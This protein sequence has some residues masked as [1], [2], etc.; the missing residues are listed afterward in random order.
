M[1]T[2][3]STTWKSHVAMGKE[4]VVVSQAMH[5]LPAGRCDSWSV[6]NNMKTWSSANQRGGATL[7][8]AEQTEPDEVECGVSVDYQASLSGAALDYEEVVGVENSRE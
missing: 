1:Q 7:S 2:S 4:H 8:A 5:V 6:L 3:C